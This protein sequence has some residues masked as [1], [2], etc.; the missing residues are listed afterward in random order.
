MNQINLIPAAVK[1]RAAI[2]ASVAIRLKAEQSD[3][4][5]FDLTPY[6]VT[7]F[8]SGV[9]ATVPPI[10][11]WTIAREPS[12]IHLSLTEADT[13]ALAPNNQSASWHW[14]VWLENTTAA[15]RILFSHGD[16]GLITP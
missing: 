1:I 13:L 15:E 10:A 3:G 5:P 12:T 7:A 8:F 4:T 9:G 14:D 2:S 11:G 6:A 16:L